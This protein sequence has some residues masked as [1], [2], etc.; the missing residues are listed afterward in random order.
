VFGNAV[1]F[2]ASIDDFILL[3]EEGIVINGKQV[4]F[5]FI[6]V[7][8]DN[9]GV[10]E[11]TGYTMCATANW[12]CR[13][14]KVYLLDLQK[15]NTVDESLMRT[16]VDYETDVELNNVSVTGIRERSVFNRIPSYHQSERQ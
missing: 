1:L 12:P 15:R 2:K 8:G 13:L 7:C 11:I 5:C 3:E 14:C 10:A 6:Q 9:L 4:Y 16:V